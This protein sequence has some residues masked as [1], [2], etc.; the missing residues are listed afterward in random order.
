M[1]NPNLNSRCEQVIQS[2]NQE[3]LDNYL[4]FGEQHLNYLIGEYVRYQDEDR[5]HSSCGHL[6]SSCIDPPAGNNTFVL[7]DIVRRERPDRVDSMV[8][9]CRMLH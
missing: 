6:P 5:T 7:D 9:T 4:L 3:C 2:I 1:Q 8:R